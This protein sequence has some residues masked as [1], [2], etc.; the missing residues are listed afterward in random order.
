MLELGEPASSDNEQE[1]TALAESLYLNM[2]MIS[3]LGSDL[4]LMNQQGTGTPVYCLDYNKEYPSA[5]VDVDPFDPSEDF[6][7]ET[8][9]GLDALLMQGYPYTIDGLS[10]DVAQGLTQFAIWFWLYERGYPGSGLDYDVW[11]DRTADDN[12]K[13][14]LDYLV[15]AARDMILPL[16]SLSATDVSMVQV[17]D[18]FFGQTTVTYTDL[19]GGYTL[20]TSGIPSD[21]T[22]TGYTGN[23]GDVLTI[24]APL[25][26]SGQS[27]TLSNTLLGHD[28]RVFSNLS[29]FHNGNPQ[30]QG[31]VLAAYN[32]EVIIITGIRLGFEDLES[33]DTEDE[34]TLTTLPKTGNLNALPLIVLVLGISLL[35]TG[36]TRL[37]LRGRT[38]Q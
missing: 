12:E 2:R 28:P 27:I 14:Y 34:E 21:I 5:T 25:S 30:D 38:A 31:V 19:Q 16:F 32:N 26:Y 7:P 8:L 9:I 36:L 15:S 24:I 35:G 10:N 13:A 22:I 33:E 1:L 20:D 29:F 18:V 6:D 3:I 23:S 17:G 37:G 11:I 4:Q